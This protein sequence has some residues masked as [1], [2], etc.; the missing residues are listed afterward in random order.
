MSSTKGNSPVNAS[1]G[2]ASFSFSKGERFK[3]PK[4]SQSALGAYEIKGSF[5][6]QKDSAHGKGFGSSTKNRFGYTDMRQTK[7]GF[8]CLDSP[9]ADR[10]TR[11]Q[12]GSFSF[13]VG[14][15]NMQKI[16]V[17]AI[18][19]KEKEE[20]SPGPNRYATKG[21]FNLRAGEIACTSRQFSMGVKLDY[22]KA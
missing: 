20:H 11:K 12:N 9:K 17:D 1:S 18:I 19:R 22:L 7:R 21:S 3:P 15:S 5:G 6:H 16:H 4:Q 8:S 14:R 13:G 10:S 2:K